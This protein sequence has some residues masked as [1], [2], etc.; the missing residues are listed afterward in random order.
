MLHLLILTVIIGPDVIV[1]RLV[2]VELEVGRLHLPSHLG[3]A[4]SEER[5]QQEQQGLQGEPHFAMELTKWSLDQNQK[6]DR[7][8]KTFDRCQ[9]RKA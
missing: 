8:A 2:R 7:V 9:E 5:G 6:G 1:R 3:R 4:L